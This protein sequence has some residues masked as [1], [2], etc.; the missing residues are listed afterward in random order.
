MTTVAREQLGEEPLHH[1]A[2]LA[3]PQARPYEET[4]VGLGLH[5]G[6]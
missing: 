1:E 3:E 5:T 4:R 2:I 6:R